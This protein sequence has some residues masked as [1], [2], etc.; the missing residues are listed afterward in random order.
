MQ[1]IGPRFTLKLRSLKKGPPA[2]KNLGA[3]SKPLEFDAGN[4]EN[5]A[6]TDVQ[7]PGMIADKQSEPKRKEVLPPT[8]DEYIWIWKVSNMYVFLAL[9][10]NLSHSLSWRLPDGLSSCRGNLCHVL[11]IVVFRFVQDDIF[12]Q[13]FGIQLTSSCNE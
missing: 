6:Q 12:I 7:E 1:E 8:E 13:T 2:V 4:D 10:T 9:Y 11:Y 5:V 3:P